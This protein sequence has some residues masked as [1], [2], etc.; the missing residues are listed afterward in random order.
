M[1]NIEIFGLNKNLIDFF[2]AI[3][4]LYNF[5][6]LKSEEVEENEWKKGIFKEQHI[7]LD[8]NYNKLMQKIRIQ[9][10][11]GKRNIYRN[12]FDKKFNMTDISKRNDIYS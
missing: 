11:R 8:Y 10:T 1:K 2:D 12:V 3:K 9:N 7:K 6:H 5:A 4:H